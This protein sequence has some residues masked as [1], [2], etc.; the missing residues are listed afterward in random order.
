MKK[1]TVLVF[2]ILALASS[3]YS[4]TPK[5]AL[6]DSPNVLLEAHYVGVGMVAPLGRYLIASITSDGRVQFDDEIFDTSGVFK[7]FIVG[8]QLRGG[9]PKRLREL[10]ASK[11]VAELRPEY[12]AIYPTIDYTQDLILNIRIGGVMKKI[13]INN[14]KLGARKA[15]DFYPAEIIELACIAQS[16]RINASLTNFFS[17]H[18]CGFK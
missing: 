9:V 13:N 8:A 12:E 4:Q 14:F 6:D 3:A 7:R 11:I 18:P 2:T 15:E 5:P 17:V 16:A 10:L 1:L